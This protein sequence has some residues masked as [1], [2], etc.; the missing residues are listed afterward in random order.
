MSDCDSCD[1]R[2]SC[3][4]A[5]VR[6]RKVKLERPKKERSEKQKQADANLAF[7]RRK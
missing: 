5:F 3:P 4:Y 6:Y 7:R 2:N 1:Y